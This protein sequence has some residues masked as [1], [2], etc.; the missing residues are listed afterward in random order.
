MGYLEM[1]FGP[2]LVAV[3]E[4]GKTAEA[5]AVIEAL[6]TP[7]GSEM[8]DVTL[9]PMMSPVVSGRGLL[10]TPSTREAPGATIWSMTPK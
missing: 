2:A 7:V 4:S 6:I 8:A 9:D 5:A 10:H 3:S 1:V